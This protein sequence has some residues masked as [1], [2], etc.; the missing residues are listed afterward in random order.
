MNSAKV[1]INRF[2]S[3]VGKFRLP[4]IKFRKGI[5]KNLKVVGQTTTITQS[6]LGSPLTYQVPERYKRKAIDEVEILC[7]NSGGAVTELPKSIQPK[8]RELESK[9]QAEKVRSEFKTKG[10]DEVEI[11]TVNSGGAFWEVGHSGEKVKRDEQAG[12][13]QGKRVKKK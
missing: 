7:I 9:I 3:T 10:P 11:F 4:L 2:A 13:K 12:S 8:A 6:T 1:N 5:N